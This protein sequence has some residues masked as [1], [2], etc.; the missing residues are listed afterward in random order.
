MDSCGR[1]D[2]SI[3]FPLHVELR[4]R[5][6]MGQLQDVRPDEPHH[7]YLVQKFVALKRI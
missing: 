5:V 4:L 3:A 6:R 2:L 7:S 1:S